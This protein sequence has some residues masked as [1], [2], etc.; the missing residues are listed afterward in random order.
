MDVKEIKWNGIN[1]MD[2]AQVMERWPALLNTVKNF[3]FHKMLSSS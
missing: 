3:G 1:W 2:L